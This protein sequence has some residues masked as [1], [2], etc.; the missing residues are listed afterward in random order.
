MTTA[1]SKAR[2]M[3]KSFSTTVY[4]FDCLTSQMKPIQNLFLFQSSDFYIEKNPKNLGQRI[5]VLFCSNE[6]FPRFPKCMCQH[7]KFPANRGTICPLIWKQHVAEENMPLGECRM[8]PPSWTTE[9]YSA[10]SSYGGVWD[11]AILYK[12]EQTKWSNQ[13]KLPCTLGRPRRVYLNFWLICARR[14]IVSDK[15]QKP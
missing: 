12:C 3:P 1:D 13:Y 6:Y 4:C 14:K 8:L 15:E 10:L 7:I 11:V 2:S 5:M 9:W